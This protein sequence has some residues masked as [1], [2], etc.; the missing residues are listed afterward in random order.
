MDFFEYIWLTDNFKADYNLCR[1]SF[2]NRYSI[3]KKSSKFYWSNDRIVFP[4]IFGCIIIYFIKVKVLKIVE[5]T[6][7]KYLMFLLLGAF[8]L[9][10]ILKFFRIFKPDPLRGELDGFLTFELDQISAKDKIF[11]VDE[12]KKIRIT[13]DDYYGKTIGSGKSFNSNLSNGVNNFCVIEL[14][15]GITFSYNYELYY[16]DDLQ[17]IK[18]EL[19]N[20]YK[21]SKLDFQNLV[22][23]LGISHN[24]IQ[25][26]KASIN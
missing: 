24:D 19:I 22:E 14:N 5:N 11:R 3:F 23:V 12:I 15:T 26:F 4:I 1:L 2:M 9:G 16:S 21:L 25:E 7:D 20:Y 6:F 18:K 10:L 13:N 17:K 8:F